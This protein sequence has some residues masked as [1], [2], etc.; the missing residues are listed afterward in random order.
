M[1]KLKINSMKKILFLL[2]AV[3]L[4]VNP[5][6]A[7][8]EA[9]IIRT[10]SIQARIDEIGY[11][12]LNSNKIDRRV[13]FCY[14]KKNKPK[15]D[16]KSITKRQIVFYDEYFKYTVTDDEVA[17]LL[18]REVSKAVRSYDGAWGGFIDGAQIKMAPKKY[19][20]F[21]DKRAVDYMVY[22][23]YNP[24]GLITYI[25]KAYPQKRYDKISCSNL[26]SKR[27]A[28]IY[29]YILTK[30]PQFLISNTYLT[31]D[32]YQNFLLNSTENRLKLQRSMR[33]GTKGPVK[34]E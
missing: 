30:Y 10:Q 20:L 31:N 25:N 4:C 15:F 16:D 13:V 26:T 24:L 7:T 21:A 33:L 22:A 17:A 23:G 29:E 28:V 19:E 14:S 5:I 1:R 12:I 18:A 8:T 32:A 34:Y 11:K 27:L 3:L 2:F 9:E 6:F